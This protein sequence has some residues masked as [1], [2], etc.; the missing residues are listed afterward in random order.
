MKFALALTVIL[1]G[2][3]VSGCGAIRNAQNQAK[4][5]EQTAK[6]K[7]AAE[8]AKAVADDCR[9]KRLRK[10]LKNQKASVECS[11]ERIYAIWEKAGDPNLDLLRISLAARLVVFKLVHECS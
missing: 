11:N 5:E 1:I 6:F 3:S 7:Q 8:D 10:E 9:D 4:Q 2:L